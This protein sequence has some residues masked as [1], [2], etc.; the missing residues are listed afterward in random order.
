MRSDNNRIAV[1]GMAVRTPAGLNLDE[2]WSTLNAGRCVARTLPESKFDTSDL[3]VKFACWMEDFDP[4][5]ELGSKVARRM[6]RVAQFGVCSAMDALN[7]GGTV[8]VDPSRCGVVFGTG[9]GGITTIA[10]QGRVLFDKGPGW[11]S[12]FAVPMMMPNAASAFI[13]MELKWTGPNFAVGSACAS[14]ANALVEAAKLI[15][16]GYCDVVLAGGAE[17][18]VSRWALAAFARMGALSTRNDSP[19][20]ASRPF[21]NERDGYV[22]SEGGSFLLLERMDLAR[23]RRARIYGELIGFGCNCD[24]Y[25]VTTPSPD[26]EGAMACMQCAL[27]DAGLQPSD[28]VQVNAHGT[29]TPLNDV[30]EAAAIYKL[31]HDNVPVTAPKGVMGHLM[32]GAGATEAVA[33]LLSMGKRLCPPTANH[34]TTDPSCPISVVHGDPLSLPDG[35]VISNSFGFGGHNVSL[36]FAPAN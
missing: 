13:A 4:A 29:A 15:R 27:D 35:A 5:A 33:A 9:T 32:G 34:T 11:L 17:A 30:T 22:M 2:F 3:P 23:A 7:D 31:F 8:D 25:H 21:D 19:E 6:D 24:A 12:P 1:S 20:T 36:I 26:G 10:E 18:G 16:H 28:I 14:S